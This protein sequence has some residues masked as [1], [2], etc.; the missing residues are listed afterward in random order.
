[1]STTTTLQQQLDAFKSQ[2]SK[3]APPAVMAQVQQHIDDLVNSGL[4][5][6]GLKAGQ[7]APDFKLPDAL[8]KHVELATL[9]QEGPV[10]VTFYRG[11][12]CPYCNLQLHA[13]Q[14]ILPQ[15]TAA[16][17]TLVAISPQNAD[18]SL[19]LAEKHALT[20]HVLSDAGN[21]IAHQYGIVFSLDE[22]LR[23]LFTQIGSDLPSFNGD[24]SWEIPMPATFIIAQDGTITFAHVDADFT[25][26]L[27]PARLLAELAALTK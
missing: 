4:A 9:L 10:V 15:I 3:Q 20:F 18:H 26:R 6:Q 27:E 2:M 24:T 25:R 13:Y 1:M 21:R 16:G 23:S 7:K 5:Q 14:Q 8:G 12:W 19:S 22:Q 17:A 11:E